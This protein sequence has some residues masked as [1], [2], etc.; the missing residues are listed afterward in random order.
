MVA[1]LDGPES[2]KQLAKKPEEVI[3]LEQRVSAWIK[4]VMEVSLIN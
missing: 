3:I 1:K 2:I 4:K